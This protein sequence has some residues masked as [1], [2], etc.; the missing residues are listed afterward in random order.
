MATTMTATISSH[1]TT[2]TSSSTTISNR[3]TKTITT[4]NNKVPSP[5]TPVWQMLTA[6]STGAIIMA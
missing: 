3:T 4:T 5:L 6:S 2:K 1:R